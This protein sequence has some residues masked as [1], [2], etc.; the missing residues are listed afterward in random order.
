MWVENKPSYNKYSHLA[1]A[2]NLADLKC[3]PWNEPEQ[4]CSLQSLFHPWDAGW[5]GGRIRELSL[6]VLPTTIE[7]AVIVM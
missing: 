6:W 1:K 5:R 7:E 4:R 3:E 2:Y